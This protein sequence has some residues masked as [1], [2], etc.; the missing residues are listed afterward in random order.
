MEDT[1]SSKQYTVVCFNKWKRRQHIHTYR[2]LSAR[3]HLISTDTRMDKSINVMFCNKL[4][5]W[6]KS[7]SNRA[8][9]FGSR[10]TEWPVDFLLRVFGLPNIT[11]QAPSGNTIFFKKKAI[12]YT[13]AAFLFSPWC[14]LIMLIKVSLTKS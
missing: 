5:G 10:H 4:S 2:L 9:I 11:V 14:P 13:S 8:T 1:F 12:S 6:T 3:V 7:L